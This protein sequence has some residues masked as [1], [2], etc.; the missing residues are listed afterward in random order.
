MAAFAVSAIG[1]DRPGIVAAV[2]AVLQ[3]RGGNVEDSAM[4]IL[5]GHFAIM[6][7]VEVDDDA[8][9]LRDALEEATADFGL[10]IA[11][12]RAEHGADRSLPTHVLSVY[13]SDQPGILA[14]VTAALAEAD[15]N[16]TDLE[17]RLLGADGDAPVYAMM[18]E[19]TT[20]QP[21]AVASALDRTC[22]DLGV[23]H[24]LRPLEAETY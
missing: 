5:A 18:I 10:T 8:D 11:V 1:T 9:T 6:L 22:G 14:G 17:T 23:D 13:G 24:T 21:D 15:A 3:D 7:L 12:T 19:L 20:E 4:T 16:I 2:A